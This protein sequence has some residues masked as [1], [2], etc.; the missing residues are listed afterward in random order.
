[1]TS[2]FA[3]L[4]AD[5][6]LQELGLGFGRVANLLVGLRV[7]ESTSSKALGVR[8]VGDSV[9]GVACG[10]CVNPV[11]SKWTII[12]QGEW[13]HTSGGGDGRQMCVGASLCSV[14]VADIL[15]TLCFEY[16]PTSRVRCADSLIKT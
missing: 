8:L 1:M 6:S 12:E 11:L 13:K 9:F 7:F 4:I 16:V 2:L 5:L 14:S 15:Y 10:T 3:L